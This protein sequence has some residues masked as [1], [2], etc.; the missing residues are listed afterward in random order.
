MEGPEKKEIN[1]WPYTIVGMILTVVM[2]SAWT[3]KVALKNP[4]QLEN[5]YMMKYQDVDDNIN[6]ILAKQRT[7][8]SK[9]T[10]SLDSNRLVNGENRVEVRLA[11]KSGMPVSGAK[12]KVLLTRPD[13]AQ[14]DIELDEF[15]Y[16][17][18]RYLSREFT[19]RKSGRWNIVAKVE[20]GGDEG[21]KKYKTFVK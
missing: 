2:L 18:G 1:F 14:Y 8:D 15:T 7:F 11:D 9:Y 13:T 3:I 4:V 5:S 6:E 17:D 20:I 19:I 12:I 16:T 10:V 21:Y